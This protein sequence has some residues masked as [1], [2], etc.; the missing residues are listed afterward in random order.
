M[1]AFTG[2]DLERLADRRK[3]G[4]WVSRALQ[5]EGSRF[6]P[7]CGLRVLVGAGA[8]P[9]LRWLTRSE[10]GG[11]GGGTEVLLGA[12]GSVCH[13]A[14]DLPPDAAG[15]LGPF[16]DLRAIASQLPADESG[17]AAQARALVDWQARTRF[18]FA[19]GGRTGAGEAGHCRRCLSDGCG[20][21]QYPRVDPVVITLV[22]D[23]ERCLLGRQ[24]RFAPG[25]YS[26]FAGFVEAGETL[27]DAARR[28]VEE[29][30]GIRLGAVSY[31]FSQPWPFPSALTLACHGV[32]S[33]TAVSRGDAELEEVRWFTREEVRQ[34]VARV[35]TEEQPR[36]PAPMTLGHQ[37]GRWW[38]ETG[39]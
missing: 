20:A 25:V 15:G 26:S 23:G 32:A 33:S 39:G 13:F 7:L 14:V 4:E 2:N 29:E 31:L 24:A 11:A 30:T 9:R 8:P 16:V 17:I 5:A 28:E 36:L 21:T 1:I 6:L 38:V 18:C 12:R 35:S 19:C 10:L 22:T 34:M 37:L 3:D 27:E